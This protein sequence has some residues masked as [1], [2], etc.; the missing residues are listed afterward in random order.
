MLQT[1]LLPLYI[2]LGLIKN[3]VKAIG[4]KKNM[5]KQPIKRKK[6]KHQDNKFSQAIKEIKRSK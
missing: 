6:L 2:E 5:G 1:M 4:A 3:F